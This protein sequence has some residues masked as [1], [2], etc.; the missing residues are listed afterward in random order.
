MTY[1]LEF[2]P[3]ALKDLRRIPEHERRRVFAKIENLQNNLAG[4][5]RS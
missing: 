3:R 1:P 5:V 2:K 4:D